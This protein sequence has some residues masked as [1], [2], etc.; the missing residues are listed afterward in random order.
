GQG[1]VRGPMRPPLARVTLGPDEDRELTVDASRFVPGGVKGTVW[2]D[3]EPLGNVRLQLWGETPEGERCSTEILGRSAADG[4]FAR[5][6]LMAGRYRLAAQ[7]DDPLGSTGRCFYSDDAI[8]LL[9]GESKTWD[10]RLVS[11]TLVLR[12]TDADGKTVAGRR[13]FL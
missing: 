1:D 9:P 11:R 12:V 10:V 13:V 4:A 5:E 6:V 8:T 3:G 2:L 7:P